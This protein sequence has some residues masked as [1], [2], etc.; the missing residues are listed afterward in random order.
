MVA[1]V[2]WG[3]RRQ[4]TPSSAYRVASLGF[5]HRQNRRSPGFRNPQSLSSIKT[6]SETRY[7]RSSKKH[8]GYEWTNTMFMPAYLLPSKIQF[9]HH[10]IHFLS[11]F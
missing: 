11:A 4:P 10:R 2:Y 9:Q 8:G 5:L 3:S 1:F 6:E 7:F